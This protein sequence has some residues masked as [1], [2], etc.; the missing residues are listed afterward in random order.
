MFNWLKLKSNLTL[1]Y[2]ILGVIIMYRTYHDKDGKRLTLAEHGVTYL[3]IRDNHTAYK[4]PSSDF[5]DFLG[6]FLGPLFVTIVMYFLL[7]GTVATFIK[8]IDI[9]GALIAT[10][11]VMAISGTIGFSG[12]LDTVW[13]WFAIIVIYGFLFTFGRA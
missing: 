6:V 3:D 5:S 10:M 9:F 1:I 12:W 2:S 7:G 11:L 13:S 8:H 4:K